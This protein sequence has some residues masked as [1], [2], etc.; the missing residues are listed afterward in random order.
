MGE[1]KTKTKLLHRKEQRRISANMSWETMK[2]RKYNEETSLNCQKK[3]KI[4][5]YPAKVPFKNKGKKKKNFLEQQ[6]MNRI[7]C[8]QFCTTWNIKEIFQA[9]G[10]WDKIEN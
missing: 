3:V 1:K 2:A 7:H 5:L 4:I 9:E 10:K 8:L 6:N